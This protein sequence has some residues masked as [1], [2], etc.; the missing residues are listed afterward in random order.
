[1]RLQGEWIDQKMDQ[2][3]RNLAKQLEAWRT[4][5]G[6][7]TSGI[8]IRGVSRDQGSVAIQK[9]VWAMYPTVGPQVLIV[10]KRR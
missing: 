4:L 9:V 5:Q 1:M 8:D 3:S 10:A 2:E 6:Q 7:Q